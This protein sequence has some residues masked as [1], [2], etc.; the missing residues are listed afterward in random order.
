MF[1]TFGSELL[2]AFLETL[3]MM[4]LS[5][6]ISIIF[7]VV[8]GLLLNA[9]S[10]KGVIKN[11]YVYA[12]LS[13]IINMIRSIPYLIL[14]VLIIPFTMF[15]TGLFGRATFFGALASCVSLSI[16]ST[17]FI[18]KVVESAASEVP[19][20]MIE[21]GL[22]LGL[23]K[24]QIVTK[25]ILKEAM[26]SIVNGIA[27]ALVSLL[28]LSAVVVAWN[29][30][31]LG[32]LAKLVGI[33]DGDTGKMLIIVAIIIVIVVIIQSIG[34][35]LYKKIKFGNGFKISFV[36]IPLAVCSLLFVA[37]YNIDYSSFNHKNNT[38]DTVYVT[39]NNHIKINMADASNVASSAKNG[40]ADLGICSYTFADKQG[41][42][43]RN[44]CIV[45]ESLDMKKTNVNILVVRE[46]DKN[47]K[48]VQILSRLITSN[49]TQSFIDNYFA[50][51]ML[52]L[53]QD[54][55]ASLETSGTEEDDKKVIRIGG[56]RNPSIPVIKHIKKEFE[57]YGYT[58][59]ID[60][61]SEFALGNPALANKTVD[62]TLFQHTPYLN[63]Y[64]SSNPDVK[65]TVAAEVYYPLFG[66][67]SS[68]ITDIKQLKNNSVIAIPNDISNGVRALK[69]LINAGIIELDIPSD[70][71]GL[72]MTTLI[73]Q[74]KYIN[75]DK[76]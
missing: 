56:M 12:V 11:K 64:L 35:L 59:I 52:P 31:G 66:G 15:V 4:A 54:N 50:G 76:E 62:A 16:A 3:E 69:L 58:L 32:S 36:A 2:N 6:L 19:Y 25:I 1:L 60:E 43:V 42:D 46:E 40:A 68:T 47:K 65:F 51:A 49:D 26:P 45:Q 44:D 8:L 21:A 20:S 7:G 17:A 23:S 29:G 41:F 71:T 9:L 18:A 61:F 10:P 63:A 39:D 33:D 53:C 14:G 48:W 34:N 30:G 74:I 38:P 67:Y 55:I 22:S 28:G 5:G 13:F 27:L 72:S 73:S 37:L 57:A 70:L 75:L 24:F